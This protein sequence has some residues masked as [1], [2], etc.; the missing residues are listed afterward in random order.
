MSLRDL[1][2]IQSATPPAIESWADRDLGADDGA[3]LTIGGVLYVYNATVGEYLRPFASLTTCALDA[4]IDGD[5]VPSAE[6]PA[7]TEAVAG[8]GSISTDGTRVRLNSEGADADT[9][10]CYLG[11]GQTG[12][13]HFL[14]GYCQITGL[15]SVG[16]SF[17]RLEVFDGEYQILF[18]P[19][20]VGLTGSPGAVRNSSLFPYAEKGARRTHVLTTETWVEVYTRRST[21][22]TISI[23]GSAAS[24]AGWVEVY[25]DHEPSPS[26]VAR[27]GD[28]AASAQQRYSIGDTSNTHRC[29]QYLRSIK[30]GRYGL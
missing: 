29:S 20:G 12:A 11:H 25:F 4:K 13:D 23:D 6:T 15:S 19:A 1:G 21:S 26:I 28:L 3:L 7:W 2:V 16:A 27:I 22:P 5:V 8:G 18:D 17:Q 30:A 10:Y 9:A 24:S 14:V